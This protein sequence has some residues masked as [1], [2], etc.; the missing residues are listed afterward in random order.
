MNSSMYI[1]K[2]YLHSRLH[3][4]THAAA[5]FSNK[6][7][8]AQRS[9]CIPPG[10]TLTKFTF[11]PAGRLHENIPLSKVATAALGLTQSYI[12]WGA[13][14]GGKAGRA[15]NLSPTSYQGLR[16][17]IWLQAVGM[18]NVTF[19][20]HVPCNINTPQA[21]EKHMHSTNALSAKGIESRRSR[22]NCDRH[23]N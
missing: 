8:K 18:N 12:Q 23:S 9:L 5:H 1:P 17:P 3:N 21:V 16:T 11:C 20:Y 10:L 15:R 13:F 4:C 2:V 19:A 6:S 7:S 14:L 22:D